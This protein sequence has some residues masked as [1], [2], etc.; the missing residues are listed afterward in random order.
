M[1]TAVLFAQ[2]PDQAAGGHSACRSVSAAVAALG[3]TRTSGFGYS[4]KPGRRSLAVPVGCRQ[5][6]C[7]A[8]FFRVIE[9]PD[10]LW[11]C[12]Q[13]RFELD[14]HWDRAGAIAHLRRLAVAA[15]GPVEIFVH[16]RD[17]VIDQVP[18]LVE[19]DLER[20]RGRL[21]AQV[22]W[23]LFE[24]PATVGEVD[25]ADQPRVDM[26]ESERAVGITE[27]V[28]RGDQSIQPSAVAEAEIGTVDCGVS[29][30]PG[31]EGVE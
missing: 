13:G 5:R 7:M 12:R 28:V 4:V 24:Q 9:L 15:Q 19:P 27:G 8:L 26:S 6:A 29:E 11:S 18:T 23:E 2:T 3:A 25:E 17:G 21:A 30:P 31:V 22:D 10:G 16:R 20:Q 1:T 14:T